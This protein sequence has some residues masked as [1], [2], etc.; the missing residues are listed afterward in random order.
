MSQPRSVLR[1]ALSSHYVEL[2]NHDP[3]AHLKPAVPIDFARALHIGGM[4]L[5]GAAR[6]ADAPGGSAAHATAPRARR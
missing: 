6:I 3:K 5:F 4:Q 1:N 2:I